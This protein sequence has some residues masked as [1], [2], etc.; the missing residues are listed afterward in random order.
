MKKGGFWKIYRI[1]LCVLV[2]L[3]VFF[4]A[5]IEKCLL[6][7]E[8]AQPEKVIEAEIAVLKEAAQ[9]NV[10][11]T[12]LNLGTLSE[13]E[14]KAYKDKVRT[15][16]EWTYKVLSGGYSETN[17][18]YGIYADDTLVAKADLACKSSEI[19]MAI[20]TVN[21]WKLAG[22]KP[23][24]TTRIADS[25]LT[26]TQTPATTKEPTE[27]V[28]KKFRYTFSLPEEYKVSF[29][30][31]VLTAESTADGMSKYLLESAAEKPVFSV[32]DTYGSEIDYVFGDT[33]TYSD[34]IVKVP[35]NFVIKSGDLDT[36]AY[37]VSLQNDAK[38]DWC[39]AYAEMPGVATYNFPKA[40][41]QPD[42][43]IYDN[44]GNEL[45]YEYVGNTITLTE[46]SALAE[47]PA[48]MADSAELLKTT[49]MWSLFLT[50]DLYKYD[51]KTGKYNGSAEDPG[52]KGLKQM[53]TVLVPDS[54]LDSVAVKYAKSVDITFISSHKLPTPCFV[55]EKVQNFIKYSDD[56]FS[57]DISFE[58]IMLRNNGSEFLIN[59]ERDK[60]NSTC[61]FYRNK[62]YDGT[63]NSPKWLLAELVDKLGTDDTQ[64]GEN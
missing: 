57:C 32:S 19:V 36:A 37:V 6:R 49:Q 11:G 26:V 47:V 40:L 17:Q 9:N 13:E 45:A 41:T 54:Y 53:R 22:I 35:S 24:S 25:T 7:Y 14:Q 3:M 28:V 50:K 61:Y 42:F 10:I 43:E 18:T 29:N 12:E 34:I 52:D 38:F 15:A 31:E 60:L 23:C 58:K 8:A 55:E 51:V 64:T 63:D 56:F 21:D 20:L 62:N 46:Q 33:L 16:K 2:I 4:L 1:V 39:K 30:D 59:G 44:F 5:Y 27:I 48:D